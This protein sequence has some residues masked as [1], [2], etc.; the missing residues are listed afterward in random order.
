MKIVFIESPTPWS[1]TQHAQIPLGILYLSTILKKI[2]YDVSIFRP[3]T[4]EECS[5]VADANVIAFSGTTLEYSMI[6]EC[7]KYIKNIN[8]DVILWIGGIHATSLP[9]EVADSKLFDSIAIGEGE[10]IIGQMALDS[11]QNSPKQFY[12]GKPVKDL[13]SIPIPDRSM[14]T[15]AHGLTIF[16]FGTNYIG[17]GSENIISSRGCPFD[18]HFCSSKIMGGKNVRFRSV[19]NMIEEVEYIINNFGCKQLRFADDNITSKK[20]RLIELCSRLKHYDLAWKCSARSST[21]T[22]KVCKAL[23]EG[24]CKEVSVGIETGDQRV[25]DF[26]NK[27]TDLKSMQKGCATAANW[28]LNVRGLFMIGTPGELKDSPEL[29]MD[30]IELTRFHSITLAF[31]TPLPGSAIFQ[32]PK[33]FNCEILSKDYS[34]YNKHF[35][36]HKNGESELNDI[37]HFLLIDNKFLTIDEQKSNIE[38]MKTYFQQSTLNNKG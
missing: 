26:L 25:L 23:S 6:V 37:G 19:D 10:N 15:G 38:R 22:D 4:V 9:Q 8:P 33:R 28:G 13:N 31:F 1:I 36:V 29:T 18:C 24:G 32:D 21:L 11:Q 27:Q 12:Y 34:K 16:S 3:K 17:T 2:H 5:L 35:W 7:A 30:F 20:T 14:I